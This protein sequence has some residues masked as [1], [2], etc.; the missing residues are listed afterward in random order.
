MGIFKVKTAA[1]KK[2]QT[3]TMFAVRMHSYGGPEVLKYEEIPRPKA[4]VGEIMIKVHAAG[5]NPV[6]WKIR[7]GY[8]KQRANHT[9]PLIPGWDFSGVVDSVGPGAERFEEGDEVFGR[10]DLSRDGAYAEYL[11]MREEDVEYKPKSVD[12]IHA[13][14]I[15]LAA[16]TVWQSLFEAANLQS[17]QS[18]LIH[19]A[20][21]G[22]GHL[23]V[24]L[25]KWAGAHVI[26]TASKSN[27]EFL[28][29]LGVD[30]AIDYQAAKFEDVVRN[31]D[32]VFDTMG[33]D[34][35]KRSWKVLAKGGILVSIVSQ[36]SQEEADS[37]GVRQSFVFVRN[38][39]TQLAEIAD[40]VNSGMLV[41]VVENILALSEADHAQELSKAGHTRGKI[42]LQII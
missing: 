34:I 4:G 19:A 32:V 7:E 28:M 37:Y 12:H 39:A 9:L 21:G 20:A 24:Q 35:Q 26:G 1:S 42:V 23:A 11:V 31:V 13:A 30:E 14:A 27:Q 25:A 10:G 8:L 40:L 6:D 17:D 3:D 18:V 41:P 29:E 2:A 22:V 38:N 16:L 36:P 33:G 15:P 5:V